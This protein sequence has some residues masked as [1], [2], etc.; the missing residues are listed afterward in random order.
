MDVVSPHESRRRNPAVNSG[1]STEENTASMIHKLLL[2]AVAGSLGTLARYGLAGLVHRFDGASF[3][4]GTLAVNV[5]GCFLVGL[6][7]A[8]FEN[9]WPVS[10][11]TRI[12]LLV[13]FMGAFT[14]FSAYILETGELVRTAEWLRAGANIAL[15]NGLGFAALL[16]GATIG[17]IL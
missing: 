15:Q 1:I 13:G 11:Q 12:I 17:R 14:T 9:R 7:A 6:L 8:L 4:W 10:A 3:P 2:L 16:A 5:T